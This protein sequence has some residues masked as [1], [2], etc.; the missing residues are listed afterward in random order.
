MSELTPARLCEIRDQLDAGIIVAKAPLI[1]DLLAHIDHLEAENT[2]LTGYLVDGGQQLAAKDEEIERLKTS[3]ALEWAKTEGVM[4]VCWDLRYRGRA[5]ATVWGNGTW[6]TWDADGV[7]GE[8]SQ[9]L[10]VAQAKLEAAGSAI[11]QGFI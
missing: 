9:E 2:R 1:R 11:E 10:T 8:N 7:G 3:P 4:E 5:V 6:H